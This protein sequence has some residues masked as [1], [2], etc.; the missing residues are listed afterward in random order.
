MALTKDFWNN[1]TDKARWDI[2][3]A[4]RGPDSN[5]GETLKWY[6][7]S[8]LRGRVR[9]IYRVGGTVNSDL[10]LVVL[11]ESF[12]Y[13]PSSKRGWN[14]THFLEHIRDAATW[15]NLPILYINTEVWHRVMSTM[16]VVNAG[17]TILKE[18]KPDPKK[19][20][21]S[22]EEGKENNLKE[23]ERHLTE[24]LGWYKGDSQ[25]QE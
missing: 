22:F 6:T 4:M 8:V 13:S 12:H 20:Y 25:C 21:S 18:T 23:L 16:S 17:V 10:K 14:C 1:L 15:M 5:Y 24:Y 7:T 11:P 19:S 2:M 3:V 9:K